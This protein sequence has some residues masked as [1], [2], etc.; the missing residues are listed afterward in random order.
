MG[1]GMILVVKSDYTGKILSKLAQLKINSQ[2]I[3]EIVKSNIAM[4]V[5]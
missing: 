1:I 3:G 5:I 4:R 2:V